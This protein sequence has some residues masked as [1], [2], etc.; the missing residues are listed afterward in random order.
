MPPARI[1][2]ARLCTLCRAALCFTSVSLAAA[3]TVGVTASWADQGILP[4]SGKPG[5]WADSY[6]HPLPRAFPASATLPLPED[7]IAPGVAPRVIP[8]EPEEQGLP[9]ELPP[10]PGMREDQAALNLGTSLPKNSTWRLNSLDRSTTSA[11]AEP[12]QRVIVRG[13]VQRFALSPSAAV[14]VEGDVH[15]GGVRK[16]VI[17]VAVAPQVYG[18]E[19]KSMQEKESV[20]AAE[21]AGRLFVE[22]DHR[23]ELAEALRN[24]LSLRNPSLAA[25]KVIT[26]GITAAKI[27]YV[28]RVH[29]GSYVLEM[30]SRV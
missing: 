7:G 27:S 24:T 22:M 18:S 8:V 9:L 5:P 29:N 12:D 16:I 11:H 1:K 2:K 23:P 19:A 25:G 20:W 6:R 30:E 10:L 26:F 14:S 21:L 17:I 13:G 28:A 3:G 4:E 15:S